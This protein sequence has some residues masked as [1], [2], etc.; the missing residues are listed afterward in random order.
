MCHRSCRFRATCPRWPRPSRARRPHPLRL[1]LLR[2]H[3]LRLH[4]WRRLWRRRRCCPLCL[5]QTDRRLTHYPGPEDIVGSTRNL[6]RGVAV[7]VTASAAAFGLCPSAAAD[8]A[9]PLPTPPQPNS[10]PQ[11]PGL[12]ALSELRPIIP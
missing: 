8:P 10:A 5:E 6:S 9:A 12:P 3:L 1:H 4:R 2:L 7:V 11:L